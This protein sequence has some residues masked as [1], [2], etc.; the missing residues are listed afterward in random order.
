MNHFL[1]SEFRVNS[2]TDFEASTYTYE[3]LKNSNPSSVPIRHVREKVFFITYCAI[4]NK[5][6][7]FSHLFTSKR[8]AKLRYLSRTYTYHTDR[9]TD[10]YFILEVSGQWSVLVINIHSL[11]HAHTST[12]VKVFTL[13]SSAKLA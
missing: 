10:E 9:E 1:S 11:L 12:G 5:I 6:Q 8:S 4:K 2:F 7:R 13:S 3:N